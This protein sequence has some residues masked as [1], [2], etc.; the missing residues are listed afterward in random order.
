ML[1]YQTNIFTGVNPYLMSFLQTVGTHT[2]PSPYP[3]FHSDHITHIKDFLNEQLPSN[4]IA[5]TEPSLQ[6]QAREPFDDQFYK[7]S[8][9]S[10]DV[11]IFQTSPS[12]DGPS[13]PQ[14]YS[15]PT[16][17]I[18]LQLEEE[19]RWMSVV[20]YELQTASHETLGTPVVRFE[21]LSPA[22]MRGGTYA[23]V[24]QQ[25]RVKCLLADTPLVE[26]DYLH[27]YESP[28]KGIPHY[29][30]DEE[31][32]PYVITVS[33]PQRKLTDVYFFGIHESIPTVS[34][35]LRESERINFNFG[36]PYNHTWEKSRF[37]VYLDY[38]RDIPRMASY[39][40]R[41]QKAIRERLLAVQEHPSG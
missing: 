40:P 11:A 25:N 35:P 15:M 6:I 38:S 13:M 1:R 36:L 30:D 5:L 16:M 4:Y 21:L 3:S 14:S 24:Y 41:D 20:V 34:I 12:H 8:Q 10:P 39:H 29:P 19:K 32:K 18:E 2:T 33:H 26:I 28:V 37:W 9:P 22:N 27:E 31:A 17:Q 7:D 23:E